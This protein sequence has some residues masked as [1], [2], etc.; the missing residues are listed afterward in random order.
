M[1]VYSVNV[2]HYP[3]FKEASEMSRRLPSKTGYIFTTGDCYTV[4]LFTTLKKNEAESLKDK[5]SGKFDVWI[6]S[7][8]TSLKKD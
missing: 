4:K 7:R 3:S 5:L 1:V 6:E 8:D 2:G